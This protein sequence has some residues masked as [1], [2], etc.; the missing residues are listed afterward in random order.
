MGYRLHQALLSPVMK[1]GVSPRF[2]SHVPD[3][4]PNRRRLEHLARARHEAIPH[5]F[6]SLASQVD[7]EQ[8]LYSSHDHLRLALARYFG[9]PANV[10][11][12]APYFDRR[13]VEYLLRVPGDQKLQP[14]ETKHVLRRA[15]GDL[16]PTRLRDRVGKSHYTFAY[17]DG[18][19]K[20]WP[21]IDNMM[22]RSRA[23]E[24]GYIDLPLFLR[25]LEIGRHGGVH[26]VSFP[27]IDATLGLE[28]W[29]RSLDSPI[30]S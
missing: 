4:L 3:W 21:Q 17:V 12:R 10:D 15:Y 2:Y 30:D 5:Y 20:Q 16:L 22:R 1:A 14:G 7:Y 26:T 28:S 19:R 18:L 13:V 27:A 11:T 24:A 6:S 25:S 8:Y 29:L 9:V 23:A